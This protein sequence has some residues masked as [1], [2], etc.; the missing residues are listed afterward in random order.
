MGLGRCIGLQ[1]KAEVEPSAHLVGRHNRAFTRCRELTDG[2]QLDEARL[3]ALCPGPAAQLGEVV[4]ILAAH[5]HSVHPDLPKA[6]SSGGRKAPQHG[7]QVA[8]ARQAAK[9]LRRDR[10]HAHVEA[11]EARLFEGAGVLLKQVPIGRHHD[12]GRTRERGDSPHQVHDAAPDQRL[13]AREPDAAN[14]QVD[15]EANEVLRLFEAHHIR[16]VEPRE[17]I[18]GHAV[19]ARVVAA[20]RHGNAQVPNP[21]RRPVGQCVR[22]GPVPLHNRERL[23]RGLLGRGEHCEDDAFR[24][25][26]FRDAISLPTRVQRAP[27]A[28]I[29]AR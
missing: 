10:I 19:R 12:L 17:P 14:A 18:L 13:A 15:H 20:I 26:R 23:A 22:R 8:T 5:D 27:R 16:A 29:R 9:G 24:A 28:L 7:P 3:Q 11:H 1:P 6:R 21:A 25:N 4:V 2:H